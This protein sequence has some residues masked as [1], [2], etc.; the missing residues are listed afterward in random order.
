MG[1]KVT[2]ILAALFGGFLGI[3]LMTTTAFAQGSI[4]AKETPALGNPEISLSEFVEDQLDGFWEELSPEIPN[5]TKHLIHSEGIER[6]SDLLRVT[7]QQILGMVT[8]SAKEQLRLPLQTVGRLIA[9]ILLCAVVNAVRQSEISKNLQ[10]VFTVTAAACVVSFLSKPVLSCI[11]QTVQ[12][13]QESA[14]FVMSFT[15]VMSGILIAGGHPGSA[16]AY[17]LILLVAAELLTELASQT[18]VPFLGIYLALCI[19][20]P[21]APFLHLDHLTSGIRSAVCWGLGIVSTLFV[22]IL[23]LQ[24]VISSGGDSLALK[25]GRFLVGSFIP[26]IGGTISDALGAARSCVQILKNTVG[27]FGVL[28]VLLI[29][30]PILVQIGLWYL[31]VNAA[32]WVGSMLDAGEIARLLSSIGQ[33]FSMMIAMVACFMLLILVSTALMLMITLG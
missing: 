5:Q 10:E 18:L 28:A 3:C 27:S 6:L 8:A 4:E 19:V 20:A 16:G 13:L 11:T 23:S 21:L 32:A 14:L 17:Q 7:P 22:G 31:A 33:T 25:T 1:Q 9:A 29:F 12:A 30:L 24:T 2:G 26:V 15:P